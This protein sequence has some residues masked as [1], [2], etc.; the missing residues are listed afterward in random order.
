MKILIMGNLLPIHEPLRVA[1]ELAMIDCLTNGRLISGFARGI[2][3][4][5]IAYGVSLAESRARFEEAFK[6]IKMAWTEDHFSYQG[7]FWSYNDVAIWPRTV[8]QPH[9]PV[10]VPVTI[11]KETMEWAAQENI[12]ISLGGR[13]PPPARLDMLRYY[14]Q[15][16]ERHGHTVTP[17]HLSMGASVYVADSK[18]QAFREAGPYT[19]Y[20]FHT[21]LNHGSI[22]NITRQRDLGYRREADYDYIR[23][24]NREGFLRSFQGIRSITL[25]Q[26][27]MSDTVCWGPPDEVIDGLIKLADQVG[28]GTLMLN[29]NQ[30]AMPHQMFM[31][32]LKRF[33]EEVLP[34]LKAHRVTR[35]PVAP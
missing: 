4:E 31:R 34:A 22:I 11:S 35:V 24:E 18:E 3:R 28:A 10:W 30:G 15:C 32:T 19:L 16:V 6:I 21:L 17:D 12:P 26:L 20:F 27:K 9:P 14:A 2:P 5:Y 8:Q 29:F 25:E 7:K 1:E 23:P 13:A 33:G